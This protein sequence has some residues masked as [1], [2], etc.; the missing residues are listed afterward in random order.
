MGAAVHAMEAALSGWGDLYTLD[1]HVLVLG[2]QFKD[3]ITS[4]REELE[5]SLPDGRI[6]YELAGELFKRHVEIAASAVLARASLEDLLDHQYIQQQQQAVLAAGPAT[7]QR[8]PASAVP[9]TSLEDATTEAA[10][11]AVHAMEAALSGWGDLYTSGP[12][13]LIQAHVLGCRFKA[14]I[15]LNRQEFVYCDGRVDFRRADTAFKRHVD[16]A[17]ASAIAAAIKLDP[18]PTP[19]DPHSTRH[20]EVCNA[21]WCCC[22]SSDATAA[23]IAKE[24]DSSASTAAVPAA[25]AVPATAATALET[26]ATAAAVP[27][28]SAVPA[29]RLRLFPFLA[30]LADAHA[31]ARRD[32]SRSPPPAPLCCSGR[33]PP[34]TEPTEP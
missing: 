5:L 30:E 6:D 23:F 18:A 8:L 25:S 13:D 33:N 28:A 24:L 9:A 10:V 29:T 27:A 2:G 34:T 15:T 32:R 20:C 12:G 22:D 21:E 26:A 4:N 7:L 16:I 14:F 17:A 1:A 19:E 11:A 3:F 31:A